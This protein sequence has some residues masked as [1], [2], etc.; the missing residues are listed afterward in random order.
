MIKLFLSF[1]HFPCFQR[2]SKRRT[3]KVKTEATT[4]CLAVVI[5]KLFLAYYLRGHTSVRQRL[6]NK[7]C[8][9]KLTWANTRVSHCLRSL[10][11]KIKIS[12]SKQLIF[13]CLKYLKRILVVSFYFLIYSELLFGTHVKNE[14]C[15]VVLCVLEAAQQRIR[16]RCCAV[17]FTT[18]STHEEKVFALLIL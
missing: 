4:I 11:D 17:C 1:Y 2:G 9:A 18:L 3:Q 13:T 10:S 15:Y 6:W 7:H 16:E 12:K 8:H 14:V 5:R